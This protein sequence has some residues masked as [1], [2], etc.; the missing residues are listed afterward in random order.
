MPAIEEVNLVGKIQD[1]SDV[2]AIANA[3]EMPFMTQVKKGKA[4]TNT[5]V[6]YPIDK[7]DDARSAGV[8]DGKDADAFE[9]AQANRALV[10]SRLMKQWR[11]PMVTEFAEDITAQAGDSGSKFNQAKATKTVELKQ[12]WEKTFL[13]NQDSAPQSSATVGAVARGMGSWTQTTAQADTPTAVPAAYRPSSAQIY[14]GAAAS[15]F[16]DDLRALLQARFEN[17]KQRGD[18]KGFVGTLIK[19]QI[20]DFS[21]FDVISASKV[22]VRRFEPGSAPIEINTSVDIYHGD[23]G[24]VEFFLDMFVA[25]MKDGHLIDMNMVE[26]RPGKLPHFEALPNLGGGPRGIVSAILT[27]ANKNP[28]AHCKIAAS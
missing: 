23:Y 10:Y 6:E 18:L 20:S 2:L 11:N 4:P 9:D 1:L 22:S 24:D 17:M 15:F 12:D 5:L 28:Q 25:S 19:N 7:Y 16:E 27:L 3:A 26:L 13:G 21:R 14:G 8:P